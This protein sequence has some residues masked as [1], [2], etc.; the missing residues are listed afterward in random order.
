MR[1]RPEG[2]KGAFTLPLSRYEKYFLDKER[3]WVR[4]A[5]IKARPVAG[6][7]ELSKQFMELV[8]SFTHGGLNVKQAEDIAHNR[9]RLENELA[10]EVRGHR[11][12][13]HGS[14]G[15]NDIEFAVQLL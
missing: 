3:I 4:Q 13:K 6:D 8:R 12:I 2:D 7:E 1:Q 9:R 11:D 5:M 10:K 14:G 15:I